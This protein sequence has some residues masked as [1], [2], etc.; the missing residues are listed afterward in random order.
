[1]LYNILASTNETITELTE[2]QIAVNLNNSLSYFNK[3]HNVLSKYQLPT[4]NELRIKQPTKESWKS[5]VK[6]AVN[7]YWTESLKNEAY[8]KSSLRYL[9]VDSM[10]MGETYSVWKSLDSIV[11]DVRKGT[12]KCRMLTG[13]YMLQSTSHKFSRANV[14][15]TCKCCG[16]YDEDL[17]H[18][19]LECH[20]FIH[21]RKP[22]YSQFKTKVINCIGAQYWRELFNNRDSLVK[23][24]LDCSRYS[25][26]KEKPECRELLNTS[27]ALIY[28]LHVTRINKLS[29]E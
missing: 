13:T 10:K 28:R 5:T 16:L 19:L 18:M 6:Q 22:I 15:A 17:A 24:I 9:N 20:A 29:L 3:V 7:K 11:S 26:I 14:S 2:R 8:E 4:L 21:Q 1:M 25:I 12:I 27:A 23:L